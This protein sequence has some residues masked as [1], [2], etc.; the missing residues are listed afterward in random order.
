MIHLTATTGAMNLE[1]YFESV[2]HSARM[3]STLVSD[4]FD[5]MSIEDLAGQVEHARNPAKY[6]H[7]DC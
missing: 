1:Q 3:V 5:G 4:S 7:F 2:E 6:G